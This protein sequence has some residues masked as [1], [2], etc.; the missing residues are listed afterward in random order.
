MGDTL[1][2][3]PEEKTIECDNRQAVRLVTL[4]NPTFRTDVR[5]IHISDLWLRQEHAEGR[6]KVKWPKW[7]RVEKGKMDADGFTEPLPKANSSV[8]NSE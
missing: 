4:E 8:S 7:A 5:D 1:R 6:I 2:V 3:K